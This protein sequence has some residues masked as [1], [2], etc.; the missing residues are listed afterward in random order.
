MTE[1]RTFKVPTEGDDVKA[2][3][4]FLNERFDKWN[5]SYPIKVDGIYGPA[6][7]GATSTFMRAWGV[8]DTGEA[9]SEGLTPWWR[10]KLRNNDRTSDEEQRF[11][12]EEIKE[13][14]RRLRDRYSSSDPVCY[15]VPNMS[16]D[17]WGY[18][19]GVHDGIDLI[20]PWK[21]PVLAICDAKVVRVAASGWWGLGAQPSSGHP[22]S[23]GDGI[24]IIE[25]RID[26]GP[27][28]KG[29]HFG[30]G[31]SEGAT[32]HEG[33]TVRAG[34]VIAHAGWANWP[35]VHFMVNNDP[36]VNGLYRGV[37][38]RDPKPYLDYAEE[39]S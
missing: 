5:I 39:N 22:V 10:S 27:F 17:S 14:R 34:D 30:Y 18:H 7:R 8:A 31:H 2:W 24:V 3:Q 35:H 29:L 37:G 36:P 33:D 28:V 12:S 13:F 23:D 21:Q 4:V 20:C 6:T 15:P 38:D 11:E 26:D 16:A 9:L 19:P 32:V 25:S 1:P